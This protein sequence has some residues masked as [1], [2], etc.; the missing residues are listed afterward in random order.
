MPEADHG[1]GSGA[2]SRHSES[3]R[4]GTVTVALAVALLPAASVAE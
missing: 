2:L 1:P 4:Y 3:P